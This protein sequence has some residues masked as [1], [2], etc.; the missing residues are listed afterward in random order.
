[1]ANSKANIV[2]A[3]QDHALV[4]TSGTTLPL[5][6]CNLVP[7]QQGAQ[8]CVPPLRCAS[9]SALLPPGWFHLAFKCR[10]GQR[11]Q[12]SVEADQHELADVC[13]FG[14]GVACLFTAGQL[15]T[16]RLLSAG[17]SFCA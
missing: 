16:T 13:Q 9:D 5:S 3:A 2:G 12:A 14:M 1:M 6:C 10:E 11:M 17:C 7:I 15:P 4:A 8:S